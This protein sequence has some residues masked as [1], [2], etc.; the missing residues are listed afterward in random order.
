MREEGEGSYTALIIQ[1]GGVGRDARVG[2]RRKEKCVPFESSLAL[3][4]A[5]TPL[6][7]TMLAQTAKARAGPLR[8][9]V[10]VCG[11]V[12]RGSEL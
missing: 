12:K 2:A 8:R 1:G 6:L 5:L 9:C 4:N 7:I 10:E 3:T 11:C